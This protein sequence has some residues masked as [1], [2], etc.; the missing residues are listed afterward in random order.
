MKHHLESDAA[1]DY[2]LVQVLSEN[3]GREAQLCCCLKRKVLL[4]FEGK[5]KMW[6]NVRNATDILSQLPVR[7]TPLDNRCT[8]MIYHGLSA[9]RFMQAERAPGLPDRPS[10]VHCDAGLSTLLAA[11]LSP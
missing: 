11:A 2:E 6:S 4:D 7:I 10:Y 5:S 8:G 1:E 9:H 3:K